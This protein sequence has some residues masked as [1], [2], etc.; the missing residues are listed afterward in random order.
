MSRIVQVKMDEEKSSVQVIFKAKTAMEKYRQS[1]SCSHG[2]HPYRMMHHRKSLSTSNLFNGSHIRTAHQLKPQSSDPP[3]P[4]NYSFE[5]ELLNPYCSY[6]YHCSTP[7]ISIYSSTPYSPVA[8][9]H[10]P[11]TRCK[12]NQHEN[13]LTSPPPYNT[14]YN[15]Q[16]GQYREDG[17]SFSFSDLDPVEE[18]L[19]VELALDTSD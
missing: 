12:D 17:G 9:T 2:D 13:S 15:L 11:S 1:Q 16:V 3:A 19:E 4:G 14:P 7:R 6:D 5:K 18:D 10:L 8:A